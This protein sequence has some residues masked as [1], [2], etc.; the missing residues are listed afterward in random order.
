MENQNKF[1]T[2]WILRNELK[3]ND[4]LSDHQI[5]ISY[6]LFIRGQKNIQFSCQRSISKSKKRVTNRDHH[7]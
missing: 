2:S 3:I 7:N 4:F 5:Q 6:Q 1:Y